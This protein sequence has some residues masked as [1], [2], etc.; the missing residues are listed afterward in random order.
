MHMHLRCQPP[1]HALVFLFMGDACNHFGSDLSFPPFVC[2]GVVPCQLAL[3]IMRQGGQWRVPSR[4]VPAR[5]LYGWL[6]FVLVVS[7]ARPWAHGGA[8]L[9]QRPGGR[10]A[11]APIE[12]PR[13]AKIGDRVLIWEGG[14][15]V[16]RWAGMDLAL[17]IAH[18][19]YGA[20]TEARNAAPLL[21]SRPACMGPAFGCSGA[22][23]SARWRPGM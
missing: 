1:T 14:N 17:D 5:D 3:P 23:T 2:H 12:Y 18:G 9:F 11:A 16:R 21:L 15:V 22:E 7:S 19:P 10:F 6:F 4:W 8:D 20:I 13:A